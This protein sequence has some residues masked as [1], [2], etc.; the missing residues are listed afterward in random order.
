LDGP[1]WREKSQ[2]E[3]LRGGLQRRIRR[4]IQMSKVA[5]TRLRRRSSQMMLSR[6]PRKLM[7]CQ[8]CEEYVTPD[9]PRATSALS[10][11]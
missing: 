7:K 3:G 1:E 9:N 10:M 11:S 2:R 4:G 8:Q 6:M 5:T